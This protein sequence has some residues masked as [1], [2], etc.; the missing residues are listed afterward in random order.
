MI[1]FLRLETGAPN[2]KLILGIPTFG[3]AWKMTEDSSIS[4]VPPFEVDGP[5]EEGK[6]TKTP[7]LLSYQEVCALAAN[8]NNLKGATKNL[9]KVGD[10]SKRFGKSFQSPDGNIILE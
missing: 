6:Y 5:A 1:I 4:G 3:R 2:N 7:G 10:P 8:P 9:R